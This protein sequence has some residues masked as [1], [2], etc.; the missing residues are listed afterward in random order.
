MDIY[1]KNYEYYSLIIRSEQ[2]RY[3]NTAIS[4]GW[5]SSFELRCSHASHFIRVQDCD[6]HCFSKCGQFA[7]FIA[8]NQ[9]L[10]TLLQGYFQLIIIVHPYLIVKCCRINAKTVPHPAR[11]RGCY[12]PRGSYSLYRC[13]RRARFRKSRRAGCC[14]RR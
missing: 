4:S 5:F 11:S 3:S 6:L 9:L 1:N 8:A 10:A 12:P 14:R 7:I 2:G 13:R